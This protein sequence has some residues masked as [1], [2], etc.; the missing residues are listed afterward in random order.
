MRKEIIYAV[1][2]STLIHG[3]LAF[4]DR[5]FSDEPVAVAQEEAIPT[6]ELAPMP[7]LEP[8]PPEE[9][10]VTDSSE[11]ASETP[12]DLAPPMQADT[13]SVSLDSPFVQ[14]IQ[15][16]APVSMSKP[17]GV[18]TIPQGRPGGAGGAGGGMKQIFDLA[19][20]DQKPVP[21][22]RAAPNHP[23]ELKRARIGGEVT[24]RFIVD[25]D[26]N[27]RDPFIVKSTHREFE[28]EAL[29]A[30]MRWKFRP[31]KKGGVAVNT[32]N[33]ELDM[34]FNPPRS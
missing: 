8:E 23:L 18:V 16:V 30:I 14:Q 4:S 21:T 7:Q 15:Q 31:G 34:G 33:V 28:P 27:V 1:L 13:P 12:A 26:G 20:L 9:V 19:S 32:R 2:G 11:P 5:I 17:T 24:V 3:G 10:E 29:K 6:I 22:Y 25:S